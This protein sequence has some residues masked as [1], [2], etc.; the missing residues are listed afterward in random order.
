MTIYQLLTT[1]KPILLP[2]STSWAIAVESFKNWRFFLL[3]VGPNSFLDAFLQFRPASYNLTNLWSIRFGFASNYYLHLLTT[4]G[5]LGLLS[6]GYL[7]W[8]V[9]KTRPAFSIQYSVFSILVLFLFLPVNFLLLFVFYIMIAL[10]A[11]NLPTKEYSESSKIAAW[12]IF[13]PTVLVILTSFYFF[14]RVYAAEIYFQKSLL[15]INRNDGN[16]AYNLQIK[17]I[18]LNPFYDFYHLAYSQTNIL[19]ANALAQKS[20]LS[21]QDRQNITVLIQQAIKEAKTAVTLNKNKAT[22]WENLANIYRQLLNFAQ[23]ADQWTI[24]SLTQAIKLD[25]VNP[26]LKLT[27]GGIYYALKNYDEAIRWFQQAVDIKP[28]FANGYY[29]LSWAYKEKGD[30]QK[31]HEAMQ[32]TLSL[33]PTDS[34]DYNK[35]RNE[36]DE[37]AKKLT[38]TKE[39]TPESK[40]KTQ[41]EKEPVGET[42]LTKPQPYPSPIIKPPIEIPE[43]QATP[44][45]MPDES[46][47]ISPAPEATP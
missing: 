36:L 14:G 26:D 23:G 19:L 15:A 7:V 12:S 3:G 47:Q 8:K 28:N 17:A 24:S 41:T 43:Q 29:N 25:P 38:T 21:D 2:F 39:A 31:A 40:F 45:A 6:F 13:I 16:Q 27:L 30:F 22:N 18:S 42:P 1:V 20:D 9:I 46:Q 4:V 34:G 33:V 5:I 37:L 44:P 11:T 32:T 10:L 35:A